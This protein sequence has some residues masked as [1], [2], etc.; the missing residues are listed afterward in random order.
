[1]STTALKEGWASDK[2]K[3]IRTKLSDAK[4]AGQRK[5]AE[6][7]TWSKG[8][9]DKIKAGYDKQLAKV[10][11]AEARK[12]LRSEYLK[13]IDNLKSTT[14]QKL[15]DAKE[16]TQ[17]VA[18]KYADDIAKLSKTKGGKVGMAVAGTAAVA[19]GGAYAYKKMKGKKKVAKESTSIDDLI[20]NYLKEQGD[21]ALP[22]KMATQAPGAS[23]A[24]RA[25]LFLQQYGQKLNALKSSWMKK[26]SLAKDPATKNRLTQQMKSALS[27]LNANKMT[28]LQKLKNPK[29]AAAA[30]AGTAALAGGAYAY[31]KMRGKNEAYNMFLL[32][33]ALGTTI[34]E[35]TELDKET[36]LTLL[37]YVEGADRHQL[38][39]LVVEG[40]ID[41][42]IST[43]KKSLLE[44]YSVDSKK[45][46]VF[47]EVRPFID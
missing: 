5:V 44:S 1:M 42:I 16:A 29:V 11:G 18:T 40:G 7:N 38:L 3:E 45:F 27:K 13:K 12:A 35:M 17:K 8:Q 33:V 30:V 41:E 28:Y 25:R 22:A 36:R 47:E 31:K 20:N 6:I 15:K 23:M 37:E 39:N 34:A 46:F 24:A 26:I 14:A 19:A 32:K 21:I 9:L 4:A 10:K 2:T 43:K